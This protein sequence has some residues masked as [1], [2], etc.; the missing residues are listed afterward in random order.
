MLWQKEWIC[1]FRNNSFTDCALCKGAC[2]WSLNAKSK[3]LQGH[4]S[5]IYYL[6]ACILYV[7]FSQLGLGVSC[8]CFETRAY[9]FYFW[10]LKV[11]PIYYNIVNADW[12]D[13]FCADEKTSYCNKSSIGSI[14]SFKIGFNSIPPCCAKTIQTLIYVWDLTG[15]M[16][17]SQYIS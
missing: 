10:C 1:N 16:C 5:T 7:Y 14:C 4:V 3:L 8:S 11:M 2:V 6:Y 13:I 17:E 12:L 15:G 9:N